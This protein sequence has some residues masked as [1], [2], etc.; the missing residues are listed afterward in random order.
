MEK[1][2]PF[3]TFE[4]VGQIR[5]VNYTDEVRFLSKEIIKELDDCWNAFWDARGNE[6]LE[7][8]F[9]QIGRMETLLPN[10]DYYQGRIRNARS[11]TKRLFQDRN[12][13]WDHI[14]EQ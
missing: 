3:E 1:I 6:D 2:E 8:I 10:N 7:K 13:D 4:V 5:E 14:S 9:Y 12:I 11:V